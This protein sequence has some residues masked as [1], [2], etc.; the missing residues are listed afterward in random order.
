[1]PMP[2]HGRAAYFTGY[3]AVVAADPRSSRTAGS[4]LMLE[5]RNIEGRNARDIA[6]DLTAAFDQYC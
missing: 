2:R 6:A 1:M 4:S 3:H 5:R